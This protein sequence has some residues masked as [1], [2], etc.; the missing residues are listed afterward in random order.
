MKCRR[1]KTETPLKQRGETMWNLL[2]S[3]GV[4]LFQIVDVSKFSNL[5]AHQRFSKGTSEFVF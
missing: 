5:G 3:S 1:R 2:N 4:P